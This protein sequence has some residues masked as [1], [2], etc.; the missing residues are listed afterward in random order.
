MIDHTQ[1]IICL[2]IAIIVIAFLFFMM[3]HDADFVS[4]TK[5][6]IMNSPYRKSEFFAKNYPDFKLFDH[7]QDIR[8][9]ACANK[10]CGSDYH[11]NVRGCFGRK[12]LFGK[13]LC[14]LTPHMHV[15]CKFCEAK[16][17]MKSLGNL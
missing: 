14:P 8:C 2:S 17:M 5:R 15:K 16:F 3:F 12:S 9:P 10:N 6:Y 4:K 1:D 13:Q 11:Y 7:N